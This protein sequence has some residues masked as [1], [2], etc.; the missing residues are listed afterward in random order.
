MAC[1]RP[2]KGW[3]C[4]SLNSSGKRGIT[5]TLSE[6][7]VDL[8]VDVPC[9]QC[10]GCRLERSRQWAVRCVHEL[11]S[12]ERSCFLTL[13]YDPAHL[14]EGGTL[15]KKHVQDFLKRYRK[16]CGQFRYFYCGEYGED[17]HRPHYHM[18][19]FGHD[20]DDKKIFRRGST[21][22]YTSDLLSKLW[23]YGFSSIGEVTFESAAYVARYVTKKVTGK[24]ADDHYQ[25]RLPEYVDMSRRPGIA[26]DFAVKFKDEILRDDSVICRGIE[27]KPP[28]YYEKIYDVFDPDTK[29]QLEENKYNRIQLAQRLDAN[30]DH[31]PEREI[32]REEFVKLTLLKRDKI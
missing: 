15:V 6:A 23:P 1:F 24:G 3:R 19:V 5:F 22:L 2:L 32:A 29:I 10:I 20:F 16:R 12:H 11:K 31:S 4:R 26:K 25:G 17:L 18:I 30:R 27:M 14:P 9:G 7:F 13:T 28:K 8:P 21:P